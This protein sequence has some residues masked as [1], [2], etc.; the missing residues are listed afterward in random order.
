MGRPGDDRGCSVAS[1]S[2]VEEVDPAKHSIGRPRTHL[3]KGRWL[4][5]SRRPFLFRVTEHRCSK[6]VLAN[7]NQESQ[8]DCRG[9]ASVARRRKWCV[10]AH[11]RPKKVKNLPDA[12]L[13]CFEADPWR[14]GQMPLEP[15]EHVSTLAVTNPAL[16]VSD[17]L[18]GAL[19]A[20]LMAYRGSPARIAVASRRR[21]LW[22]LF[23]RSSQSSKS[24]FGAPP[25]AELC[26]ARSPEC[27][28]KRWQGCP[29]T[30]SCVFL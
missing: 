12:S 25:P 28:C 16:T 29:T 23:Q 4:C 27:H 19:Q 1:S 30:A 17:A 10:A 22:M 7:S 15:N 20:E 18:L 8:I 5:G 2:Q 9:G 13:V 26:L 24:N 14:L 11:Q 6:S 3:I 21:S